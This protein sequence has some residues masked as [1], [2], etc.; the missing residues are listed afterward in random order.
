MEPWVAR[1][2]GP[3]LRLGEAVRIVDWIHSRLLY[4]LVVKVSN[5]NDDTH[6]TNELLQCGDRELHN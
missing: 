6:Y 2:T 4:R 5:K 1:A 3:P